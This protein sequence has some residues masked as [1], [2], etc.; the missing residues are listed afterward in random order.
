M[1]KLGSEEM[2]QSQTLSA[3]A[4]WEAE[5]LDKESTTAR[6]MAACMRVFAE[7]GDSLSQS[8]AYAEHV[9]QPRRARIRL[10]TGHK[11]KGLEFDHVLHLDPWLVRSGFHGAPPTDQD[12]NLDY[13]NL[14][15]FQRPLGRDLARRTS[16][17]EQTACLPN[18]ARSTTTTSPSRR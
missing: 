14:H 1:K 13:R 16:G 8:L 11:A 4:D 17:G 12:K 2:T 5:K 15:P 10:M 6:D 18:P 3:I 7:H 9:L